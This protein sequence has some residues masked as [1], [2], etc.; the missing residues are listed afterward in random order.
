MKRKGKDRTRKGG[1]WKG[2]KEEKGR[3]R[4]REDK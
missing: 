3:E 2:S 4:G 1:K